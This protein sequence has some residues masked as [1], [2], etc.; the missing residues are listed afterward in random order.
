MTG[1]PQFIGGLSWVQALPVL[2]LT[3][4]EGAER[5]GRNGFLKLLS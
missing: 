3:A 5:R 1:E 2:M 4:S